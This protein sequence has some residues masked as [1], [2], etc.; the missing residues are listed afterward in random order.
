M[1][2]LGPAPVSCGWHSKD[3][4]M[5]VGLTIHERALPHW[6]C[7]NRTMGIRLSHLSFLPFSYTELEPMS[8][9]WNLEVLQL[10]QPRNCKGAN[11]R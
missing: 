7:R 9:P 1:D 10:L 4:R 11:T 3:L 8:P 5:K 2:L 6:G